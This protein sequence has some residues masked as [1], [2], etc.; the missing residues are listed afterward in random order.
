[1]LASAYINKKYANYIKMFSDSLP[2]FFINKLNKL[3]KR[4][5]F[6]K[7]IINLWSEQ[8]STIKTTTL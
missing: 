8:L 5:V 3:K 1:M 2:R 6:K 7:I 4:F